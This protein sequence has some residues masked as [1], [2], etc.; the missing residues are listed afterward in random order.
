MATLDLRKQI[1]LDLKKEAGIENQSADV[2]WVDDHSGS[3]QDYH[4]NGLIQD[5]ADRVMPLG[6]GFDRDGKVPVYRFDSVCQKMS[7]DMTLNN[8]TGFVK[9]YIYER[10]KMGSTKY[11]PFINMIVDELVNKSNKKKGFLGGLFGKKE[12]TASGPFQLD[13]PVI[14]FVATDGD[15]DWD[16]KEPARQALIRASQYGI[17]FKFMAYGNANFNF[18]EEM[19]DLPGRNIDNASW[20]RVS[21][22]RNMP[23]R[24]LYK[25][26]MNELPSFFAEAKLKGMVK[27]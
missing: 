3:T 17:H 6:L 22:I 18:L 21:D 1:V 9:K 2:I 23:D 10:N 16:D 11:A 12:E 26:V 14:V 24:E 13:V 7:Q 19:D 15:N 20:F 8:L 4:E 27:S 5:V 25:N